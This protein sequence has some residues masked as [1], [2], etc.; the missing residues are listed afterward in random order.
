MAQNLTK[1]ST[2]DPADKKN[3]H[4]EELLRLQATQQKLQER[5]TNITKNERRLAALNDISSLITQSLETR[6]VLTLAADKVKEVMDADAIT[7]FLLDDKS[8]ELVLELYQG[9]SDRLAKERGRIRVG[10]GY[11][12]RVAETGFTKPRKAEAYCQKGF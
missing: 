9:Y 8:N 6:D 7:V 10:E 4:Q 11:D 2:G 3:S 5:L 1:T 12:G